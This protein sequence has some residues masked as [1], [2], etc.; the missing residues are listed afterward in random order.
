MFWVDVLIVALAFAILLKFPEFL[1]E[2]I[3]LFTDNPGYWVLVF[4][5]VYV[6][7]WL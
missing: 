1:H 4:L 7:F 2:A 3:S 5:I 6:V